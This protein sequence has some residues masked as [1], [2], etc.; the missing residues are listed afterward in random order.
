MPGAGGSL[1]VGSGERMFATQDGVFD[2]GG[3]WELIR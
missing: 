2:S 3:L 1:A